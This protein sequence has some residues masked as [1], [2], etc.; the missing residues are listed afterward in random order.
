MNYQNP[1]SD[2][3]T[4]GEQFNSNQSQKTYEYVFSNGFSAPTP[5]PKKKRNGNRVLVTLLTVLLCVTCS[6]AAG[7]SGAMYAKSVAEGETTDQTETN[8]PPINE[9]PADSELLNENP[10]EILDKDEALSSPFGSAG[11]DVFS[12]MQVVQKVENAVVVIDVT[13]TSHNSFFVP[14]PPQAREAA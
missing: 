2:K 6:F 5:P 14:R 9:S 13:V 1:H 7:C 11:D 3:S 8:A 10:T 12:V 4:F